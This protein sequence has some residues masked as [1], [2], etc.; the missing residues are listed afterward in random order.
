MLVIQR[1]ILQLVK[2]MS[3]LKL[4]PEKHQR[5]HATKLENILTNMLV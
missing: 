2:I 3:I 5:F 1:V 4:T